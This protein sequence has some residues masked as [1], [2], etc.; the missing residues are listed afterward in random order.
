MQRFSLPV[1][2]TSATRIEPS[3]YNTASAPTSP[4]QCSKSNTNTVLT[5][6]CVLTMPAGSKKPGDVT[7]GEPSVIR[8][9]PISSLF[10]N[11]N[12]TSGFAKFSPPKSNFFGPRPPHL[13][14]YIIRPTV[15]TTGPTSTLSYRDEP[16][17]LLDAAMQAQLQRLGPEFSI[18][19]ELLNMH[20]QQLDLM[21]GRATNRDGEIVSIQYGRP[22]ELQTVV[23]CMQ[24]RPVIYIISTTTTLPPGRFGL[25]QQSFPTTNSLF[26]TGSGTSNVGGKLFDGAVPNIPAPKPGLFGGLQP[27]TT[28]F[29]P[30]S[31]SL[32][33][34][35]ASGTDHH[36]PAPAPANTLLGTGPFQSVRGPLMHIYKDFP[37]DAGSRSHYASPDAY[38][39][40][41]QDKGEICTHIEPTERKDEFQHYQTLTTN[42]EW[43]GKDQSLE[44]IRIADYKTGRRHGDTNHGKSLFGGL[45]GSSGR[46]FPPPT[47]ADASQAKW[48]PRPRNG[49]DVTFPPYYGR[50]GVFAGFTVDNSGK[51]PAFT[52]SGAWG[53][54]NGA[55]AAFRPGL[56]PA[57][58]D[59]SLFESQ[60]QSLLPASLTSSPFA[61]DQCTTEHT[62][63][64][65]CRAPPEIPVKAVT[66]STSPFSKPPFSSPL[67]SLQQ[68]ASE[69]LTEGPR[70]RF[71]PAVGASNPSDQ[72]KWIMHSQGFCKSEHQHGNLCRVSPEEAAKV[73]S[74]SAPTSAK[75]IVSLRFGQSAESSS[76]NPFGA[77]KK[78]PFAAAGPQPSCGLFGGATSKSDNS[79]PPATSS[80]TL[81]GGCAPASQQPPPMFLQSQS[82][83]CFAT[84]PGCAALAQPSIP[85]AQPGSLFGFSNA[86]APVTRSNPFGQT[87]QTVQLSGPSSRSVGGL[88]ANSNSSSSAPVTPSQPT[89]TAF[90]PSGTTLSDDVTPLAST[91]PHPSS[92]KPVQATVVTPGTRWNGSSFVTPAISKPHCAAGPTATIERA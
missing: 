26:P 9:T 64:L 56:S 23:G 16:L 89:Q 88:F 83:H 75:P 92:S 43:H 49:D 85:L 81:F 7:F 54:L 61:N 70:L 27:E 14:A 24:V 38:S 48:Y 30:G 87:N 31:K 80:R 37:G 66:A 90:S 68:H 57:S 22:V 91:Y 21:Q 72:T 34:H 55:T 52:N 84:Q 32:F 8:P 51:A 65:F 78:S 1:P 82:N 50:P 5:P 13:E 33:G 40:H 59:H 2:T 79:T 19:D 15:Q 45:S 29:T 18:V 58:S 4:D 3:K 46:P 60:T 67:K 28:N 71:G 63:S 41:L 69:G 53:P 44:E 42:K 76:E 36:A 25:F 10:A 74:G 17:R 35:L 73:Q 77:P 6:D 47:V 11:V 20:S 12:S 86:S 62:H 39:R